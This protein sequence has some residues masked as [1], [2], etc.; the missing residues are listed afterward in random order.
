MKQLFYPAVALMNRLPMVYKFS[1]ISVLFLLPIGGLAQLLV[2]QLN[3]SIQAI[4][5]ELEGLDVLADATRLYESTV[6][7]RDYQAAGQI[8]DTEQMLEQAHRARRDID[9]ILD[10]FEQL[11]PDFDVQ[12]NWHAQVSTLRGEWDQLKR[13][14]SYQQDIDPQFRYYHEFVQRARVMLSSTV[15]ISGLAQD[16]ER[17]NQILL[18]LLIQSMP[19]AQHVLGQIRSYGTF[20][21]AF[22][23]VGHSLSEIFNTLYDG[24]TNQ[25]TL[26][27]PAIQVVRDESATLSSQYG[28]QLN[29][30]GETLLRV[31]DELDEHVIS[32]L[33]LEESWQD[34]DRFVSGE[35][36]KVTALEESIL[37]V[38]RQNLD[39]RLASETRQRTLIFVALAVVLLVIVFLYVGFFLSVRAAVGAFGSAARKVAAG[40]MT[41]KIALSNRDELGELGTEFNNMTD[42]IAELIRSVSSTTGQV[43]QQAV[44]VNESAT[45]NSEAVSRQMDET[46]QISDAMHQMVETVQEVA[47]SAQYAA[48]SANNAEREAEKGRAIVSE[49]ADTIHR[50]ASEIRAAVDVINR[51][52]K[53]SASISQVL[54]EIKAIAEQTNLL[55]LNAAIEAAR[56]GE[57]GRGFAVVAD[58]VRS[59]SQRTHKST[60]EIE[61]MIARLQSGVKDAV[62][63]MTNSHE[64]TDAT[65]AKSGEVSQALESIVSGIANIVDM[66]H[67]I[68]QAAEEQAAV[69]KNINSN[70]ERIT[71]VG[72]ETASNAQDTLGSANE[73]SRLTDSL[74]SLVKAFRV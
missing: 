42:R 30:F 33:R 28:R 32:P 69:A 63:A 55:A 71:E 7:F 64:V 72:Q 11:R 52:S 40:D 62:Q 48:D 39:Q 19:Q 67:Q 46:S 49:T 44:L 74:E 21:L 38:I 29:E 17:E 68:A 1:L 37:T 36:A 12:G 45:A 15:Q 20:A 34:F 43:G 41:V 58:E 8:S 70:V 13:E 3:H 26:I 66:S 24:L 56:A 53:D 51:V 47:Q 31:R 65:V 18:E 54:V 61:G 23:Q 5:R 57:Q 60:E 16:P 2:G 10:R 35:I 9:E 6:R 50:L 4:E 27:E 14:M 25:N 22:G 59:L 73:M